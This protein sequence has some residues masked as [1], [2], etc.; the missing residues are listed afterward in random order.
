MLKRYIGD[1]AFY[2]HVSAV[3]IPIIVQNAISTFV[4]LLDN[5][6]VG[7]LGTM[8][9]SGV[10]IVNNL[11]FIFNLCVFGGCA[12]AG[13]FTAQFHGSGDS[14]GVR[15]TFR[16]KLL[17][18]AVLAALGIGIFFWGG[19]A[20]IGLYLQGDG[21]PE[22]AAQALGYG[23]SYLKIMLAGLLPFALSNTYASTLRECGQTKVPMVSG[24]AAVTVNLVLNYILIF[25]HLGA[26]AMGVRGAA[27][28][29]VISRF[30]ELAIVAG[31][32]HL[33]PQRCPFIK[34]AYR[35][36]RIPGGLLWS[37]LIKGS[38]LLINEML[39]SMGMAFLN[40][41]YSTCGLD[42]VPAINITTVIYD[43]SC[44]VFHALGN[45]VGIIIGQM[46]GANRSKEELWDTNRKLTA[47]SIAAGTFFALL[48]IA[49]SGMFP[50]IYNTTDSVRQLATQL[51][52]VCACIMPLQAY[53]FP[54]YFTMRAGGK[55]IITFLFDCGSIWLV[56][57]PLAFCLS[58]L[59]DIPIVPLYALCNSL[60]LL[61]CF[62][63]YFILRKG[64]W[65][66]NLTVK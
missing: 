66:Q 50:Q 27:L 10:S 28:A 45:V 24:I 20:L 18:C 1:R 16:F 36:L 32:T 57:I 55:T 22:A 65:I 35:S 42:V 6:M 64:T 2:R 31:W 25:G 11:L 5:I 14:A 38:P 26:P 47:L 54:V 49:F 43:L 59:T 33:H 53:I 4:S 37:I 17:L 29:T 7:Q 48:M 40:Q 56:S 46:L 9:M 19:D 39:W 61:K 3:A 8:Q 60:D 21:D 30:V 63:G 51:I 34:D 41:C 23:R 44:V 58:R 13:I 52:I 15:H 12:G 62:I